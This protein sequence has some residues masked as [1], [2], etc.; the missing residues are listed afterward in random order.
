MEKLPE[1]TNNEKKPYDWKS[2]YEMLGE[3]PHTASLEKAVTQYCKEKGDALD[4]AAGNMRDTKYLLHEGFTVTAIDPSPASVE[5]A[6]KLQNKNLTM[7]QEV[8]GRWNFPE[9]HFSLIN[10]QN[11][12]FHFTPE[13]FPRVIANIKKSLKKGGV[14]CANFIGPNDSWNNPDK[15]VTILTREQLEDV[16][17]D[18]DIK[19]VHETE[20]DTDPEKVAKVGGKVNKHWHFFAVIAVKK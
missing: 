8:L 16:F 6:E 18:F 11:I 14:L 5:I 15:H 2:Y 19:E 3:T 13:S 7:V 17:L 9:D 12:L 20:E 10:A 1:N 4:I